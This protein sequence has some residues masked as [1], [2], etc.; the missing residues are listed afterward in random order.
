MITYNLRNRYKDKQADSDEFVY[1]ALLER[2]HAER[3][4][5]RTLSSRTTMMM[6]IIGVVLPVGIALLVNNSISIEEP[7]NL[8]YIPYLVVLGVAFSLLFLS[9]LYQ[10]LI[11]TKIQVEYIYPSNKLLNN[12]VL[13]LKSKMEKTER[14]KI[15]SQIL[16]HSIKK[17]SDKNR[18]VTHG[19]TISD[20][21]FLIFSLM[22]ALSLIQLFTGIYEEFAVTTLLLLMLILLIFIIFFLYYGYVFHYIIIVFKKIYE[23]CHKHTT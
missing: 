2:F 22:T 16:R 7:Y 11:L 15:L 20:I 3:D 13:S 8:L 9:Y 4:R 14:I 18:F 6:K 23:G 21:S 17:I 10:Y 5:T 1:H 12:E 19:I